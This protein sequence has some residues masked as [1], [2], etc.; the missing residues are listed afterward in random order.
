MSNS[1]SAS[2]KSLKQLKILAKKY[3]NNANDMPYMFM[4]DKSLITPDMSS[5]D[6]SNVTDMSSMFYWCKSLTSLDLSSFNT[7]KVTNMSGMFDECYSLESLNISSFD[8][9]NV[10]TMWNMFHGCNSLICLNLSH[11]NTSNVGNMDN[12]FQSC[13]SLR[14]LDISSFDF[15]KIW[16]YKMRDAFSECYS[17][18]DLKFGHNLKVSINLKDCPLSHESVISVIDGLAVVYRQRA[19]TLNRNSY[20]A[21]SEKEIKKAIDKNWNILIE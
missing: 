20:N 7:S 11:F 12:M 9:S 19:L 15:S 8:T 17:L 5:L 14:S 16:V 18:T 4:H 1:K 13:I 3:I 2:D 21:L 10:T 6:T